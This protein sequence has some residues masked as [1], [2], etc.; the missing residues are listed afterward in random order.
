MSLVLVEAER[1]T[2][3]VA[4]SKE[5]PIFSSRENGHF[6]YLDS[7]FQIVNDLIRIDKGENI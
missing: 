2:K 6:A 3:S 1:N 4:V 5:M 7:M